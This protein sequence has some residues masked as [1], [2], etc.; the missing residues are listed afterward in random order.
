MQFCTKRER[1]AN[2]KVPECSRNMVGE[3]SK[4]AIIR[5]T[6]GILHPVH[7]LLQTSDRPFSALLRRDS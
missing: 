4:L 7:E 6:A 5:C 2:V 1:G 3:S